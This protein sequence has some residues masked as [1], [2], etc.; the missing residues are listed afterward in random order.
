MSLSERRQAEFRLGKYRK[1]IANGQID[2][3]GS[4]PEFIDD[5]IAELKKH[6][7]SKSS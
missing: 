3:S 1:L 6:I 2:Y 5:R 7:N 4:D